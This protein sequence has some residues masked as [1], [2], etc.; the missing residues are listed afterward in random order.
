LYVNGIVRI[1]TKDWVAIKLRGDNS[2]PAKPSA[3]FLE[4]GGTTADGMRVDA[5]HWS[6]EM[7]KSTVDVSKAGEKAT[8]VFDEATLA[9]NATAAPPG[10]PGGV[11]LPTLPGS[12]GRPAGYPINGAF[13][14]QQQGPQFNRTR[15]FPP[16]QAYGM[17]AQANGA[18]QGVDVRRRL[19]LIPSGQ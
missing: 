11:R 13:Q 4:V 2:D 3:F 8:L 1:G 17:G 6:D 18:A 10:Q 9:Q 16:A 14:Q 12:Q 19:R 7:G 5:V 15:M